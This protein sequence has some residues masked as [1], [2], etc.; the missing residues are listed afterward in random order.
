M[1]R[2]ITARGAAALFLAAALAF[3]FLLAGQ[4]KSES[5]GVHPPK[6]PAAPDV[7]IVQKKG[8]HDETGVPATVV[9]AG[10]VT[11]TGS[12]S[13]PFASIEVEGMENGASRKTVLPLDRIDSIEFTLWQGRERR[14]NEFAFHPVRARIVLTDKKTIE[15]TRNISALNRVMF[16]GQKGARQLYSFFYDYRKNGAWKN[17]GKADMAYPETNPL[18]GTLVK[19]SFQRQDTFNPLEILF[20]AIQ[21]DRK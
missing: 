16:R 12:L 2:R 6:E 10:G 21:G 17:S 11:S 5:G 13:L 1:H 8:K 7:D 9:T 4:Q 14:K 19:I 20:K 3:P 15:S 18:A